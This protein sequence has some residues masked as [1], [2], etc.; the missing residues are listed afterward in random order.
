ML[1]FKYLQIKLV[2]IP[3]WMGEG[4]KRR[5]ERREAGAVAAAAIRNCRMAVVRTM[6]APQMKSLKQLK[7]Q[8]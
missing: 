6:K 4:P 8:L 1:A 7:K 3:A 2:N 5:W